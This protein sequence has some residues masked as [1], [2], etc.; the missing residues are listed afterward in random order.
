M[1]FTSLAG[2]AASATLVALSVPAA[3]AASPG[4]LEVP[5]QGQAL[6]LGTA[7]G[8]APAVI[9]V[10]RVARVEDA[11]VV[12]WSMALPEGAA[13]E[14]GAYLGPSTTSFFGRDVG[15]LQGDVALVDPAGAKVYRPLV[16]DDKFTSCICS[17]NT[18]V[19]DLEPGQASV[20]WSATAPLPDDVT[21]VD[22]VV[23]EQVIPHVPVEEGLLEPLAED[24][25]DPVILGTG[26]PE[27]D[28]DLLAEAQPQ[29]PASYR[30]TARVSNLEESVTTSAGQVDL[31]ADVLFAKDSARL[32]SKATATVRAAAQQIKAAGAGKDLTVTGHTDSDASASYNL[33][34]SKRRAEAVATVL[35]KQLGSGYHLTT[36]G[37]G[38]SEPIA[39]NQTPSGQAKN[40]RV[41]ITFSGG[42]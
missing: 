35:R 28:A 19:F 3:G 34:L 40:R 2:L 1:R 26:W 13:A 4:D 31:A 20:L 8:G 14:G 30:V 41:S 18:A 10:H 39:D 12:Y 16:P 11:T 6:T 25:Q 5:V 38:E 15:P 37:K 36:V 24:Q 29:K 21:S 9:T 42:S 7:S 23:A 27:V 33:E 32:T 22:V 17:S